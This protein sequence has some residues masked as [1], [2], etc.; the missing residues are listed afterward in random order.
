M[1]PFEF[2]AGPL[3]AEVCV[4][5]ILFGIF[6]A[7]VYFYWFEYETDG[8]GMKSFVLTTWVLECA[9]TVFC[10]DMLYNYFILGF[11]D[12]A[13]I[14]KVTWSVGATVFI[15]VVIVA[16]CQGFYVYRIYQ[17]SGRSIL[18]TAVPGFILFCRCSFGLATASLLYVIKDWTQFRLH[19]AP[20]TTL[21]AG[22]TLGALID[23]MCTSLLTY[24]LRS[25]KT[26]FGRTQRMVQ[27]LMWY[28]INTGALTMI[29][30][31]AILFMFNF[32]THSLMFVGFVEIVSKLY[33][34]SALAMINARHHVK[35]Q[36][37]APD[38]VNSIPLTIRGTGAYGGR[39]IPTDGVRVEIYKDT[40][41]D[42]NPRA[43]LTS[44]TGSG[45]EGYGL[46]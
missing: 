9:H 46:A 24:Y 22:L 38:G 32:V 43:T 23:L 7:Q 27:T 36:G 19:V 26:T 5:L 33:A 28:T 12:E 37:L 1:S 2:L 4:A 18:A 16:M 11:G 25:H 42:T 44:D 29:V 21:N 34:N 31:V 20:L 8:R 35:N 6:T 45:K 15:E 39:S 13:G 14:G 10:I 41:I 17:L 3:L 40:T 30:S